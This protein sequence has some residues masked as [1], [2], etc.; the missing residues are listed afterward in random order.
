MTETRR[1]IK[2]STI[3]AIGEILTKSLA[4]ILIPVYTRYFTQ[5]EYGIYNL[6]V[7]IWPVLVI[8]YGKGFASYITRGYFD[9]KSE[10]GKREFVGSILL[11]SLVISL[12]LAAV[13]HIFGEQV[14]GVIFKNIDY[15]PFLQFAV[16]IAIIKLF[17]NNVLAVYRA[18]RK[19]V[20]V[21]AL[22][23]VN[24]IITVSFILMLVVYLKMGLTGAL[25]GQIWGL[26]VVSILFFIYILKDIR[27]T[28][29]KKYLMS[30][31]VFVL[32]LVPHALSGWVINLSDRIFIER[33]CT[34]EDLA[35]YS[36]GY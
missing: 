25:K 27:F 3:Y 29:N 16:G 7:T 30:A 11:F 22:S 33:Y 24:F 1:F 9:V 18:K 35:I 6:V 31:V 5:D 13:T 8:L 36:L 28:I 21:V 10:D 17:T 19:P 32:P 23:L 34:L 12:I 20:S 14:F 15:K 4:F 26:L 2:E